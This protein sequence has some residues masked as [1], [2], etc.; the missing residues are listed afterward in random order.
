MKSRARQ[1]ISL[2]LSPLAAEK[3]GGIFGGNFSDPYHELGLATAAGT[4]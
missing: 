3:F 1:Q 4:R 2:K